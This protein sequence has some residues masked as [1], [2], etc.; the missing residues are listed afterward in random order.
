MI[1]RLPM[2]VHYAWAYGVYGLLYYIIGY[3]RKVVRDNLS[4]SYPHLT[5]TELKSLEKKFYR[6]LSDLM[7]ESVK[8]FSISASE[9]QRRVI[10]KNPELVNELA[11]QG[12]SIVHL[13]GHHANWEWF[14][15][16]FSLNCKHELFFIYKPL[17]SEA[18][19]AAYQRFRSKFGAKPVPMKA[20]FKTL[21]SEHSR[22]F[23]T[24]FGSDQCPQP[25]ND[26]IWT[27][28]L[29]RTTPVYA[30]AEVVARKFNHPVVFGKMRRVQRGYYEITFELLALNPRDLEPYVL[31]DLHSQVLT[32]LVDE[33]P[34][35]WIW[36]HKRWKFINSR[37][38]RAHLSRPLA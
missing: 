32:D 25:H 17:S 8:S 24:Y 26:Y 19:E 12:K 7:A 36:S 35:L 23:A 6:F 4:G 22:P 9:V 10:I 34:E 33:A 18:F 28:F 31:T 37:N 16:A 15:F 2:S 21:Q 11:A 13:L 14:A 29:H 1:S 20:L 38:E 30:G 27:Q 3:R 5:E